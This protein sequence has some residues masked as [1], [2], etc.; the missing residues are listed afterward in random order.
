MAVLERFN[1][2]PLVSAIIVIIKV[3]RSR[4]VFVSSAISFQ[5][6]C[7][8]KITDYSNES[9]VFEAQKNL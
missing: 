3:K 7:L 6:I 8:F 5:K 2:L 1:S 9:K 4:G